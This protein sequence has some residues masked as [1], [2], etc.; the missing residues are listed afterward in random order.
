MER[1]RAMFFSEL[2]DKK[3]KCELCGHNCVIPDS[4][5]G[6][7][8]VRRNIDGELYSLN[9]GK[10]I[11]LMIDPIE[12]KP[13]YHFYPGSKTLSLAMQGCNFRCGFC[14]NSDISQVMDPSKDI[15]GEDLLPEDIIKVAKAK[16]IDIISYTYTEPT[17]FYEFMLE[18][19][20]LAK[21]ENIKNIMVTN[22]FI[23]E[24]P[25]R[26]L[27]KFM[28][29][30]NVDLKSF[31]HPT[32]ENIIGGKLDVVLENLEIIAKSHAWLEVT[33]LVIPGIN[34]AKEEQ[35]DIAKFVFNLGSE[36]PWHISRFFP[37]Y[38][39][40]NLGPTEINSLINIYNIGKNAGLKYVYVGNVDNND[41]CSTKCAAC[42]KDIIE[43]VGY[44]VTAK[45]GKLESLKG[46]CPFCADKIDGRF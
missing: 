35:D 9:Y 23:E 36:V 33:T 16:N 10:I 4:G 26:E 14:Q 22:G 18:T 3:V 46:K 44:N 11:S 6:I 21:A 27:L 29:A 5:L 13:L 42:G 24:K 7:C 32:Y 37:H 38:K 28:D 19:S 1:K 25:L 39:M 40:K 45:E 8:R 12:K 30:F 15:K 17:T 31:R 43:R 41:L 20:I 2:T 34:D